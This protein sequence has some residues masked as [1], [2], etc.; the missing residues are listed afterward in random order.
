[1]ALRLTVQRAAWESHVHSTAHAVRGLVPVVKGNGYGFGRRTLH[2]V[3][4]SLSDDVCVGTMHELDG[5]AEGVTPI[6]LTPTAVAPRATEAILTVGSEADVA[7]LA[8]WN[9][10]VI[11]KLQ[12]SMRRYGTPPDGLR[13][14]VESAEAADLDVVGYA[15]HLPLAGADGDRVAEVEAWLDVLDARPLSVSHLLPETFAALQHRHPHRQFS[16]RLG[17]SL[18]HG[19]KSFLHLHADVLAVHEA[20]AGEHAGYHLTPVPGDGHIVMVTAGSAHG[21]SPLAGGLSPF[22]FARTRLPLLEP[23]HMHSSMLFVDSGRPCPGVGEQVDVQR[24]LIATTVDEIEW[25]L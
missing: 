2:P 16:L 22:H 23:P 19:D 18:W 24:P 17:T 11:V 6:V 7:V 20:R 9:G 8:G 25:L 12:S 5:V 4:Q 1:M 13:R 10:R 21:V 15:M 3:A 14:V